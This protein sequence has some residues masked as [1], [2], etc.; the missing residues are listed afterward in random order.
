MRKP[1]LQK[2]I[3][4]NNKKATFNYFIEQRFEAGIVLLGSEVKSI[5]EGKISIDDAYG[6]SVGNELFL[7]NS[8]IAEYKQSNQFNHIPKR[9]R[10]LLLH[11]KEINKIIGK[12]KIKGYT[13]TALSVYYNQKNIIKI[14]IGIGI[15]KQL[16][17]KRASIKERDWKREQSKMLKQN[18]S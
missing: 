3:I 18:Y 12:I 9:T 6:I 7:I 10:K 16:H 15:G 14:E 8:H 2:N 11:R 1:C 17:D 13:L 4:A 5:R